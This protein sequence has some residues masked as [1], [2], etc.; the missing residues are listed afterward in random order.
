MNELIYDKDMDQLLIANIERIKLE[1]FVDEI[2]VE[3]E[4]AAEAEYEDTDDDE[5]HDLSK[6]FVS[7]K[8]RRIALLPSEGAGLIVRP[9]SP[10]PPYE[11]YTQL[12]TKDT[13]EQV[14][15]EVAKKASEA[16]VPSLTVEVPEVDVG[17]VS[18]VVNPSVARPPDSR[19]AHHFIRSVS[20]IHHRSEDFA[21][22]LDVIVQEN[23]K[24]IR[25]FIKE[26]NGMMHSESIPALPEDASFVNA[27]TKLLVVREALAVKASY[28]SAISVRAII[29]Y[30]QTN[31]SLGAFLSYCSFLD[32]C[33]IVEHMTLLDIHRDINGLQIIEGDSI[34]RVFVVLQGSITVC[35]RGA[36][37]EVIKSGELLGDAVLKGG[38]CWEYSAKNA[39]NGDLH[40]ESVILCQLPVES[41]F[42]YIGCKNEHIEDDMVHFWKSLRLWVEIKFHNRKLEDLQF[43]ALAAGHHEN[44]FFPPPSE[45][46]HPIDV[47]RPVRLRIYQAGMEIFQQ[48]QPRNYMYI[49]KQGS[50]TYF[51]VFPPDKVGTD[52]VPERVEIADSDHPV[53]I[54]DVHGNIIDEN[55]GC[56]GYIL[57]GDFSIMDSDDI[58]AIDRLED[59]DY[60][61]MKLHEHESVKSI[62][63]HKRKF[64]RYD[65]H[66]NTLVA[67][68]RCEVYVL[69][70]RETAK[71]MEVFRSLIQLSNV[72]Y[73]ELLISDERVI[74]NYH[75]RQAWLIQRKEVFK[76]I[77]KD[78]IDKRLAEQHTQGVNNNLS[79]DLYLQRQPGGVN[80][81]MKGFM[82]LVTRGNSGQCNKQDNNENAQTLAANE[83][84]KMF[85]LKTSSPLK[86]KE[87]SA[88]SAENNLQY[89]HK[90]QAVIKHYSRHQQVDQQQWR[91]RTGISVAAEL[92]TSPRAP[93]G[94]PSTAIVPSSP[95][96]S[97]DVQ[98]DSDNDSSEELW[99]LLRSDARAP[100]PTTS[101]RI[102]KELLS[103]AVRQISPGRSSPQSRSPPPRP[104]SQ[105]QRV[106]RHGLIVKMQ[107]VHDLV[108]QTEG[109]NQFKQP[110]MPVE[111]PSSKARSAPNSQQRKLRQPESEST[112]RPLSSSA[113]VRKPGPSKRAEAM[114]LIAKHHVG[115]FVRQQSMG[116]DQQDE[117]KKR[118]SLAPHE[119]VKVSCTDI[120]CIVEE[121]TSCV[122]QIFKDR[123]VNDPMLR[124][125][126]E[127][128][129]ASAF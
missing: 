53:G 75:E 41:V 103:R 15:G 105:G 89:V 40:N 13:D 68:T 55:G 29:D 26:A 123:A 19:G 94:R 35:R 66:R 11:K 9:M 108:I 44:T 64:H 57:S 50:A 59:L 129:G 31:T 8:D 115:H 45:R 82:E 119:Y 88:P 97:L 58:F 72:R 93:A 90:L 56:K 6:L 81:V 27:D 100:R 22:K 78:L 51:R 128:A 49:M 104:R 14:E 124:F 17:D 63:Y 92:P 2:G 121:L 36:E 38:F 16:F 54:T 60:Q 33:S 98:E 1:E 20:T 30:L 47:T 5:Y 77:Q 12:L 122:G 114:Q 125:Y 70:L 7:N 73:P 106:R 84:A 42:R 62:E 21:R 74:H 126:N 71:S 79:H 34:S 111:M 3:E 91:R 61:L 52:I 116:R 107:N 23:H 120:S 96:K 110:T 76:E 28:R 127:F 39:F 24:T 102:P 37:E 18:A 86:A 87:T 109:L 65:K 4:K 69:P 80:P 85:C 10:V 32:L 48:G 83:L 43:Q 99:Q 113:A 112:A 101:Q 46:F 95:R 67:N 118:P 117:Q 25:K